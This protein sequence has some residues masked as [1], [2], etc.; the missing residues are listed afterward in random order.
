MI[1]K[2]QLWKSNVR[3]PSHHSPT[4]QL[5]LSHSF[6]F[7]FLIILSTTHSIVRQMMNDPG[8]GNQNELSS[9][10]H[11][12][13][14]LN[15]SLERFITVIKV[16]FSHILP[17]ESLLAIITDSGPRPL[18]AGVGSGWLDRFLVLIKTDITSSDNQL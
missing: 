13:H 15:T 9:R 3:G 14:T 7:F 5:P 12:S 8:A 4:S 6:S 1:T 17:Q 2:G 16:L 10:P 11:E 18:S